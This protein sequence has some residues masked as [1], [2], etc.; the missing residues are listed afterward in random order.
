MAV[1]KDQQIPSEL[2]DLYTRWLDE[3][4]PDGRVRAKK[5]RDGRPRTDRLAVL[6]G[7]FRD[8]FRMWKTKTRPEREEWEEAAREWGL[9]GMALFMKTFLLTCLCE[10]R[11]QVGTFTVRSWGEGA[12]QFVGAW[13]RL[14][15]NLPDVVIHH[16]F[17]VGFSRVGGEGEIS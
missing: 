9:S 10:G 11:F 16:R 13:N 1:V 6:F 14:D 12:S 2:Y 7:L 15:P 4:Y 8:G 5:R 3:V 17:T